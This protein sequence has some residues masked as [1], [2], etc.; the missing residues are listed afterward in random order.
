M[1]LQRTLCS[2]SGRIE[3]ARLIGEISLDGVQWHHGDTFIAI[4][5]GE[6][7]YWNRGYGTDAMRV[8]L[9]YAFCEL[10]LHRISLNVFGYNYRALSMYEKIGFQHEGRQRE[11]LYRDGRRWDLIYMG[12]LNSE[13]KEQISECGL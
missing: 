6:R 13:W 2:R 1:T 5:I 8:M 3:D 11:Y 10:N 4:G 12:I 9:R 7:D